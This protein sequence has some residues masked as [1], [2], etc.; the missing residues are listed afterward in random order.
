MGVLQSD[1]RRKQYY[2]SVK[3]PLGAGHVAQFP[4]LG[5]F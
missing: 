3:M 1:P 5:K 4:P 2:W